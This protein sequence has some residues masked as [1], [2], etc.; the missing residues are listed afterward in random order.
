MENRISG[1][2][3][4][5]VISAGNDGTGALNS[6]VRII[7]GLKLREVQEAII[8]RG[9]PKEEDSLRCIHLGETLAAGLDLG[10]Y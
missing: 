10:I 5:I 1:K 8:V 4:C 3:Y 6:M 2:S 9:K 7:T